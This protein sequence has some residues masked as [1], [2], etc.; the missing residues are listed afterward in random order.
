MRERLVEWSSSKNKSWKLVRAT[1]SFNFIRR[2]PWYKKSISFGVL[3]PCRRTLSSLDLTDGV[4]KV[5]CPHTSPLLRVAG[6]HYHEERGGPHHG[7]H[8][9]QCQLLISNWISMLHLRFPTLIQCF[10]NLK[11]GLIWNPWSLKTRFELTLH[12][13]SEKQ[14]LTY[15]KINICVISALPEI[16]MA[17]AWLAGW[18]M[19]LLKDNGDERHARMGVARTLNFRE[20]CLP[21]HLAVPNGF[22]G[23][24]G[25]LGW[26]RFFW[27]FNSF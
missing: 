20:N 1:V 19:S 2:F 13:N 22:G 27:N 3:S 10:Y 25:A 17:A 7:C 14:L 11:E 15:P 26:C 16:C 12:F 21:S 4:K 8:C 9:P 5:Q 24:V 23:R 6:G 18:L